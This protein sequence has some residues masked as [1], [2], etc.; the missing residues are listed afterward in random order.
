M[1][2]CPLKII[3]EDVL[4]LIA[5]FKLPEVQRFS[6]EIGEFE[7]VMRIASLW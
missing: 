3:V 7:K 2:C 4:N 1:G 5:F 6:A